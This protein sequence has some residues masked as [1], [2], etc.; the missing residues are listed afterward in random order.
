MVLTTMEHPTGRRHERSCDAVVLVAH[1]EA[2]DRLWSALRDT[3]PPGVL[4]L[5]VGD[6][7]AP[8]QAGDA[9]RDGWNAA[10]AL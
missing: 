8:R 5:R 9:V 7:V 6:C 10:M 1:P 3:L 2:D 4:V